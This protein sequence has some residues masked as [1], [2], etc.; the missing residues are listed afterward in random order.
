MTQISLTS[1][2]AVTILL[3]RS[4]IFSVA[5]GVS[6]YVTVAIPAESV[7]ST[8]SAAT[9]FGP[10]AADREVTLNLFLGTVV[11]EVKAGGAV[12]GA[13]V[14]VVNDLTTGG[15]TSALSAE[16]GKTLQAS[17][18][19]ANADAI[20]DVLEAAATGA[21]ADLARIQSSVSEYLPLRLRQIANRCLMA[22]TYSTTFKQ[23]FTKRRHD[24]FAA[25]SNIVIGLTSRGIQGATAI[26]GPT[27]PS[28]FEASIEYPTGSGNRTRI[29]FS[30]LNAGVETVG[31]IL[32]SDP[33]SITVRPGSSAT[34]RVK[35]VNAS[36][37]AYCTGGAGSSI[38]CDG[39][40]TA[41]S[42]VTE[43]VMLDDVSTIPDGNV[44]GIACCIIAQ[45]GV[46]ALG[47]IGDS[48]SKGQQ[49]TGSGDGFIGPYERALGGSMPIINLGSPGSQLY[50]WTGAG[51]MT[52][53]F[54]TLLAYCDVYV[55]H[56]GTNDI[57]L[58]GATATTVRGYYNTFDTQ[59][60]AI[61]PNARA[62]ISD[63]LPQTTSTDSWATTANQAVKA[64]EATRLEYNRILHT[65]TSTY[66][67]KT[68]IKGVIQ[69]ADT[70]ETSYRSG[71]WLPALTTDGVHPIAEG[72]ARVAG[73]GRIRPDMFRAIC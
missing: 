41:A 2:A 68:S 56:V 20:A 14:T 36:G 66:R 3:E 1:P 30:G 9:D 50:H 67:D 71:I 10:Y 16:M 73:S 72:Y 38:K 13:S 65:N 18:L 37:I 55:V 21:P 5:P 42:G 58:G 23:S 45:S 35:Q 24:F 46:A 28:T 32:Y 60:R 17:K 6:S 63:V 49:D 59:L 48:I 53:M 25:A 40:K 22:D 69:I 54:S 7:A 47:I 57:Y 4:K 11:Y 15:T 61:N 8:V 12:G 19:G 39:Q 52:G 33:I 31:S 27:T 51:N 43:D 70:V 29:T 26:I 34:L 44:A 64:Q 62:W